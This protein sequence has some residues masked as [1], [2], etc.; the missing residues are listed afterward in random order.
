ST[1]RYFPSDVS[2]M[3]PAVTS[4]VKPESAMTATG[5]AFVLIVEIAYV[6]AGDVVGGGLVVVPLLVGASPPHATTPTT[7]PASTHATN[8]RMR[9]SVKLRGP[10]ASMS[11]MRS[12]SCF[13]ASVRAPA[14][15]LL[16]VASVSC[17]SDTASPTP[18]PSTNKTYDIATFGETFLPTSQTIAAGDT[19]RWTFAVAADNLGHNVLFKPRLAG[20][21]PDIPTEVRSGTRS[22]QFT[23]KGDF[24]YVCDLHGGMTGEIIVQ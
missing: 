16:L 11:I 20:A 8:A 3:L 14:L 4:Q 1:A 19:V 22:L 7:A 12:L 17:G 18:P 24:N 5:S 15:T 13:R 2:A 23:A 9:M 10:V 21:P 6:P